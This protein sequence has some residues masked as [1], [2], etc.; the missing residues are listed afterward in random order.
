MAGIPAA[1][2][3]I[4]RSKQGFADKRMLTTPEA[5]AYLGR[6]ATWLA[7]HATRLHKAGFPRPLRVVGGYD[8]VAIDNW[9]DQLGDTA[10]NMDFEE[11][12][13]R[14]AHG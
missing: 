12:W 11:A 14:A 6:S 5:A 2:S 8:R 13:E 10:I 9:L 4:L 1:T 7:Q 3:M